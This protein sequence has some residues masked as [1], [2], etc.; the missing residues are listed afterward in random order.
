MSKKIAFVLLSNSARPLPSTRISV[1]NMLPR[2]RLAGYECEVVFEPET[3]TETPDVAGIADRLRERG[4]D[5][6]FFQKVHGHSVRQELDRLRQLGIKT[7]YGVCDRI[8][9]DMVR[10][11]DKT[12][13]VTEFLKGQHAAELQDRIHVVHD[14]IER[15]ALLAQVD[16]TSTRRRLRATMVTSGAPESIPVLSNAAIANLQLTVIGDYPKSMIS[17]VSLREQARRVVAS[18]ASAEFSRSGRGFRAVKWHP[19][20]VYEELLK[21]DVGIIPVDMRDHRFPESQISVW[22]VKSENRLT[23]LMGLGLPVVASPVP[24]YLDVVVQGVNGYLA[25]SVEEWKSAL[26]ALRD[27][28]LRRQ[29]GAAAR[30]SVAHRFSMDEQAR[31]LIAVFEELH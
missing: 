4:F 21:A 24:S 27:P 23:L 13:I 8:D 28:D 25:T 22:E 5:I 20:R 29:V 16:E 17:I 15:P 26:D 3:P 7:V 30:T 1:L 2:L 18:L 19:D 9:D 12:A 10:A 6:A 11:T 14:G 31:K